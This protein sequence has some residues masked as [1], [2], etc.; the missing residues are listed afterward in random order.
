MKNK[1]IKLEVTFIVILVGYFIL[2]LAPRISAVY[3]H[4]RPVARLILLN[5]KQNVSYEY[6]TSRSLTAKNVYFATW[7]A[8]Y[9]YFLLLSYARTW[10]II[11]ILRNKRLATAAVD[12]VRPKDPKSY[13]IIFNITLL[14]HDCT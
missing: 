13:D 8:F 3:L 10:S 7:N 11:V 2:F 5:K 4:R 14:I 6:K 1:Y 12:D 9:V